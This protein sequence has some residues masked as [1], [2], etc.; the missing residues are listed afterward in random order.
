MA[1]APPPYQSP[2][3]PGGLPVIGTVLLFQALALVAVLAYDLNK[4]GSG[5][6][7]TALGFSYQR[8]MAGPAVFGGASAAYLVVALVTAF[9]A[10]AGAAWV[11][12]AAVA[13]TGYVGYASATQLWVLF[14]GPLGE[15][16]Y[17]TKPLDHLL[18]TLTHVLNVVVF[19]VVVLAVAATRAPG[20]RA[21]PTGY[22]QPPFAPGPVGHVPAS[23][24]GPLPGPSAPAP[25][26]WGAPP[27][28]A[29]QPPA[30]PPQP[31]AAGHGA[32]YAY[33]PPPPVPPVS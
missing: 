29:P 12:G 16:G 31:P 8:M 3:R 19:L 20:A 11:R 26:P 9:R 27:P 30:A 33:P 22:P 7:P 15:A 32:A 10:F 6:L 28:G 25:G 2:R 21:V 5:Y 23:G 1:F 14:T 24:P 18:L 13:L 17:A 4:A